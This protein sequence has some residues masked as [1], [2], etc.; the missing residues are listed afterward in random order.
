MTFT[1]Q[2]PQ[3]HLKS[4]GMNQR[5]TGNPDPRQIWSVLPPPQRQAFLH[6]PR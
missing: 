6:P 5:F 2:A 4:H 3:A 1:I